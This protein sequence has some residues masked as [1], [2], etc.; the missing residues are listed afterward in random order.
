MFSNTPAD[1]GVPLG[2]PSDQDEASQSSAGD[3]RASRGRLG[4]TPLPSASDV[5]SWQQAF[6]LGDAPAAITGPEMERAGIFSRQRQGLSRSRQGL[7]A[8]LAA[9]FTDQINPCSEVAT[10]WRENRATTVFLPERRRRLQVRSGRA[11]K[12]RHAALRGG[13]APR[14]ALAQRA[15]PAS[16]LPL[17]WKR[18]PST[19]RNALRATERE[20]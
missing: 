6:E 7:S 1:A 3:D 17:C 14:R 20:G 16:S 12:A 9:S 18:R 13:R 5:V 19:Q 15:N 2:P 4:I 10:P 11:S 8:A